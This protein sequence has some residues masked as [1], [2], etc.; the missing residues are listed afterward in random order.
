MHVHRKI[1]PSDLP[2]SAVSEPKAELAHS[3]CELDPPEARATRSHSQRAIDRDSQSTRDDRAVLK[4]ST[5]RFD[6]LL[7]AGALVWMATFAAVM[8]GEAFFRQGNMKNFTYDGLVAPPLSG[9]VFGVIVGVS[10]WLSAGARLGSPAR[11]RLGAGSGQP[12]RAVR[13]GRPDRTLAAAASVEPAGRFLVPGDDRGVGC[14]IRRP[15]VGWR[16]PGLPA[17]GQP[18]IVAVH[19]RPGNR[20]GRAS[21]WRCLRRDHRPSAEVDHPEQPGPIADSPL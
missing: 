21:R 13:T 11:S 10:Q 15:P 20:P 19:R 12:D 17:P 14:G 3:A 5:N 9:V 8:I 2:A 18:H 6:G 7:P 1:S 4:H 16:I